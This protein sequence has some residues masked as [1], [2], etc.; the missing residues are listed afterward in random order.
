MSY[1][2]YSSIFTRLCTVCFLGLETG[3]PLLGLS[4]SILYLFSKG[5]LC[6]GCQNCAYMYI[7]NYWVLTFLDI[8]VCVK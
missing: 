6:V 7:L 8:P 4:K 3:A 2:G 1:P 5:T